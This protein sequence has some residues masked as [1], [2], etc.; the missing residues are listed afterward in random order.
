MVKI[1]KPKILYCNMVC[2]CG[3]I[4]KPEVLE[5]TT[6]VYAKYDEKG[7]VKYYNASDGHLLE[8][9]KVSE[10][11]AEKDKWYILEVSPLDYSLKDSLLD[12]KSALEL[13]PK[14]EEIVDK[15]VKNDVI[16]LNNLNNTEDFINKQLAMKFSK[17]KKQGSFHDYTLN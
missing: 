5:K 12:I 11:P 10:T 7:N 15:N 4:D 1:V 17:T 13:L 16:D 3:T 14:V 2:F 9:L 8:F 6:L